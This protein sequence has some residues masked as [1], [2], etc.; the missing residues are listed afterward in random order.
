MR[1]STLPMVFIPLISFA[2]AS[3]TTAEAFGCSFVTECF[4]AEACGETTFT[5]EVDIKGE[6]LETEFGDLSIV[7]VKERPALKTM[8]ATGDGAEYL[9]SITPQGARL[10]THANEGPLVISYLGSCEGAF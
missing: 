2:I 7:A 8:F 5:A 10:T 6:K 3:P 1:N 4:E 9:L